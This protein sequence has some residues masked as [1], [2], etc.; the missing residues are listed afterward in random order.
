MLLEPGMIRR[1]LHGEVERDLHAVLLAGGD[2]G[3]KI[4]QR[5]QFRVY[6]VVAAFGRADRIGTAGIALLR[7]RRVVASLAIDPSDRVDRREV[8]DVKTHRGDIGQP[9]DAILEGAVLAGHLALAA[10]DHFVPGA[11]ARLRPVGDERKQL[12][13]RQV[14]PRLAF[15]HGVLQF[16]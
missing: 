1:A 8:D 6:G 10:W 3:A 9:R 4:F 11:V 13:P 16:I 5:T 15:G 14:G 7:R 12:R 2:E